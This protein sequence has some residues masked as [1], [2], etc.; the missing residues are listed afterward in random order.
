MCLLDGCSETDCGYRAH[1]W[2]EQ[3]SCITVLLHAVVILASGGALVRLCAAE[4]ARPVLNL[5][6]TP[7][8]DGGYARHIDFKLLAP[9]KDMHT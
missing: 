1:V 8:A 4:K 9:V 5:E 6:V 3:T 7:S 2:I